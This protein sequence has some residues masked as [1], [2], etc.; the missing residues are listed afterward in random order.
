LVDPRRFIKKKFD[1]DVDVIGQSS[2]I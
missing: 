2:E 1:G